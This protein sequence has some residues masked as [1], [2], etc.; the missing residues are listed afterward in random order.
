MRPQPTVTAAALIL[1]CTLW[2][3][4]T[5]ADPPWLNDEGTYATIGRALVQGE[6]LYRQIWDNKPPAIYLLYGLVHRIAGPDHLLLGVRLCALLAAVAIQIALYDL[7][8][9]MRGYHTALLAIALSGLGL[10]LPLLDG[11][12]ANAELFLAAS[13]AAGMSLLWPRAGR[14]PGTP[15]LLGAGA[16]FGVAILFKLPAGADLLAAVAIL[17]AG[18]VPRLEDRTASRLATSD[19]RVSTRTRAIAPARGVGILL[20]GVAIPIGLVLA[21]L[22]TRGLAGDALYATIGYNRGYIT[23]G[24]GQHQAILTLAGA[25]VPLVLLACGGILARH[26]QAA[27][28]G[29]APHVRTPGAAAC[30]WLGMA[31]L[32]ALASGRSYPHYYLQ[33]VPPLALSLVLLITAAPGWPA[34]WRLRAAAGAPDPIRP[35]AAGVPPPG[36]SAPRRILAAVLVLWTL[37][38]PLLSWLASANERP[39]DPPGS[40]Q[41]AY[42]A[43]VWQRLPLPWNRGALSETAFGDRLDPRVERNLAVILYLKQHPAGPRRLFIWGNT[44]WI[45]YLSG[46]AHAARFISTSYRPPIPGSMDQILRSL[47]AGPP[48]I[49]VVIEPPTP[50]SPALGALVHARYRLDRRIANAEIYRLRA[51]PPG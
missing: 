11:T 22:A 50:P 49:I 6:A 20:L 43:H 17:I 19:S 14:L 24:Q 8:L 29:V 10:D 32:G 33:V 2:R 42:Y 47:R 51:L 44:P 13:T 1:F 35:G 30:W 15:L 5:L 21:W 46:Y 4:P 45:Y 23:A 34:G 31:V 28:P 27:A 26:A 12:A 16:S 38:V 7:V 37:G 18:P 36:S 9:H 48:P 39:G 3:L 41:L 40:N 25:L